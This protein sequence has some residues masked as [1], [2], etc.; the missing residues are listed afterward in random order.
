VNR[1]IPLDI[2]PPGDTL[3]PW[4]IRTEPPTPY[5]EQLKKA[6]ENYDSAI[7]NTPAWTS[8][9]EIEDNLDSSRD[10]LEQK[11]IKCY[12]AKK[13]KTLLMLVQ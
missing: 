11:E 5:Q 4:D 7:E 2:W 10:G 6:L 13:E 3:A 1:I 9:M 8:P 12:R